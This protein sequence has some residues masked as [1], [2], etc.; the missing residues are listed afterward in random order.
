MTGSR[1][2]RSGLSNRRSA[3]IVRGMRIFDSRFSAHRRRLL[4]MRLLVAL[5]G[6]VTVRLSHVH[7][8]LALVSIMG[9]LGLSRGLVGVGSLRRLHDRSRRLWRCI[10]VLVLVLAGSVL[11]HLRVSGTWW[12]SHGLIAVVGLVRLG[13]ILDARTA[14]RCERAVACVRNGSRSVAA[15]NNRAGGRVR[16]L[17]VVCIRSCS[18]SLL[19]IRLLLIIVIP[20][21][22]TLVLSAPH[23]NVTSDADT[24]AL[25][26]NHATQGSA[27]GQAWEFLRREYSERRG[28]DFQ[29]VGDVSVD[30]ALSMGSQGGAVI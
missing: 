8:G 7:S 12:W 14:G 2:L 24:A 5:V 3:V 13:H 30:S 16:R 17:L 6:H 23:A 10:L 15:V 28:L 11:R 4:I 27:L 21:F 25:F 29:T 18:A 19:L 26:G 20:I 22:R 9:L 1:V